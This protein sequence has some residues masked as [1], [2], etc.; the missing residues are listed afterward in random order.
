MAAH[1]PEARNPFALFKLT[2]PF[3]LLPPF[4]AGLLGTAAPLGARSFASDGLLAGLALAILQAGGQVINQVVDADLDAV[5]KPY[6]PIPSGKVSRGAA[7]TYGLLL[8][9]LGILAG[10]G[11]SIPFGLGTLLVAFFAA[12]YS[13]PPLSPR[14]HMP[15]G[16]VLW[17]GVS[18]GFLPMFMVYSIHGSAATATR[19]GALAL[20]WTV[21]YQSTKDVLDA[22]E[23]KKFGYRSL[24]NEWGVTGYNRFAL[25]VALLFFA[26]SAW[27]YPAFLLLLPLS[28]VAHLFMARQAVGVENSYAWAAFYGGIALIYGLIW[29]LG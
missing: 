7:R 18:R 24:P 21:G 26:A 1:T 4:V 10:F 9:A 27:L 15:L 20:L 25:V 6:R 11:V 8:L 14:R 23:D 3:T 16:T 29:L 22:E 17:L 13:L 19:L 2:R 12:F 5:M 28:V